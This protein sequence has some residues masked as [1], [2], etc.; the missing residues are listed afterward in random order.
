MCVGVNEGVSKKERGRK[1]GGSETTKH[2][3]K[4]VN[5]NIS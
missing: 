5:G 1:G 2:P 4:I 3:C